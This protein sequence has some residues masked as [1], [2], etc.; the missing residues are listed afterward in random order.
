MDPSTWSELELFKFMQSMKLI[1][2]DQQFG[3]WKYRRD[4]MV[5]TIE[6]FL[7]ED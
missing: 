2:E 7:K 1:T 6:E 5:N 4:D 3:D